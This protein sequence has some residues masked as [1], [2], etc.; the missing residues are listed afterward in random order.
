MRRLILALSCVLAPTGLE[1]S[2]KASYQHY[3]K[4]LLY[5]NQG[6]HA[7]ALREYEAALELDPQSDF[8]YQQAAA[9]LDPESARPLYGLA[10]VYEVA[11]DTVNALAAYRSILERE[12]RNVALLNHLGELLAASGDAA[13]ARENFLKAKSL[14]SDN[15][16][17]C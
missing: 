5:S 16:T 7:E 12:P 9:S 14:V 13:R 2:T 17:A 11:Q 10:Q 3:L 1:A 4:A 8:M 6:N 15:P